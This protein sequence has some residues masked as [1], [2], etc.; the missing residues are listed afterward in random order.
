MQS[1]NEVE[2]FVIGQIIAYT[3]IKGQKNLNGE[4]GGVGT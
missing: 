3:S 2:P 1:K 4:E